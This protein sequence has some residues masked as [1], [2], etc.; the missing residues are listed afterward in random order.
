MKKIIPAL[1]TIL[2]GCT[3][4]Q[5]APLMYTSKQVFG[6]D[7]S[8]PTTES[9]GVS[10]NVGFKNVDAAY[11]P[12]AVSKEGQD[13]IDLVSARYG[14][15]DNGREQTDAVQLSRI[16]GLKNSM[17]LEQHAREQFQLEAASLSTAIEYN[18]IAESAQTSGDTAQLQ[19]FKTSNA[20][21][22]NTQQLSKFNTL[23]NSNQLI[24]QSDIDNLKRT[25]GD[26]ETSLNKA[27]SDFDKA[28]KELADSLY[29][30]R[31][32]AMSVYGSFGS[33]T[34]AEN[35]VINNKLGKM[36][37]TGVAAQN[38]TE[39]ITAEGKAEAIGKVLSNCIE[40]AKS[41][42]DQTQQKSFAKSCSDL[43][44][45]RN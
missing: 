42:T 16:E 40:L 4:L 11:V 33:S 20:T 27:T 43:V 41:I 13:K 38:L 25:L 1:A 6:V 19:V 5:Q 26:S 37:S 39:G 35:S 31:Q 18:K 8:A 7:I 12:I 10:M 24:P 22:L 44:L 45:N 29:V 28:K 14:E 9:S 23:I 3:P 34:G 2:I 21:A 15:G 17:L 32:D 30:T 36:F